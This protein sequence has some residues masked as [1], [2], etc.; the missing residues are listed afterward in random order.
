MIIVVSKISK[1]DGLEA[2]EDMMM[3]V[4]PKISKTTTM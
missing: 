1:S 4:T 3:V 2:S